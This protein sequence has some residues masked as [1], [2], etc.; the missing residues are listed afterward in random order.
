MQIKRDRFLHEVAGF[1][2]VHHNLTART[3]S[4]CATP[5]VCNITANSMAESATQITPT[6]T[7]SGTAP[8]IKVGVKP[9]FSTWVYLCEEGPKHLNARL[10]ELARR[11]RQDDRNATRRTNAGG[12]HYAFD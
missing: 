11:L 12:W 7:A 10:V 4:C 3:F 9:L 6:S 1:G 5:G 2:C 8:P